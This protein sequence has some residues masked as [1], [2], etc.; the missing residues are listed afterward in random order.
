MTEHDNRRRRQAQ[1]IG[2][3]PA[4][5]GQSRQ[6]MQADD[7][8]LLERAIRLTGHHTGRQTIRAVI[9]PRGVDVIDL[10]GSR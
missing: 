6:S 1:S 3:I 9:T 5:A 4:P 2:F 10:G 8:A 7:D